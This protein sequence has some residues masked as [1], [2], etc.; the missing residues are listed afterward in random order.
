[1][2]SRASG[3]KLLCNGSAPIASVFSIFS[4]PVRKTPPNRLTSLKRILSPLPKSMMTWVCLSLR[5][6]RRGWLQSICPVIPRRKTRTSG[7]S[8]TMSSDLPRLLTLVMCLFRVL[9]TSSSGL[10]S[11]LTI[12]GSIM[13]NRLIRFPLMI[14][15]RFLRMVSTSG[16]SG[17]GLTYQREET[18]YWM[19]DT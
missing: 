7:E 9:L 8:R 19:F 10:I 14:L 13:V 16:S 3:V 4:F 1:M 2:L 12:P 17:T 11:P 6:G 18:G 15:E 5:T